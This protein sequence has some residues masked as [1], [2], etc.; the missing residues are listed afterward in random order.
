MASAELLRRAFQR[1][2]DPPKRTGDS[3]HGIFGRTEEWHDRRALIQPFLASDPAVGTVVHRLGAHTGLTSDELDALASWQRECLL[4]EIDEAVAS[5]FYRQTELSELLANAGVLPMFGF[6]TRVRELWSRWIR[7][8]EDLEAFTISSRSLD[9]AI[10]TFSPGAEVVRE[11]EIHT[12]V[13]FAAYDLKAGKAIAIDPL[14]DPI[15]LLQCAS[16]AA[17]TLA[18]EEEP[19]ACAACGDHSRESRCI[20]HSASEPPTATATTTTSWKAW[21]ASASHSSRCNQGKGRRRWWAP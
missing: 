19:A 7:S 11:G 20:S 12:C 18:P 10:S 13:G 3:I 6:P 16:C 8:R 17:T 2:P 9:Q 4:A 5:P 1:L 15:D 14:G 21:G